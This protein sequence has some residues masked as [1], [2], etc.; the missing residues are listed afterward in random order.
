M[1]QK[2]QAS[3]VG[4]VV[5]LESAPIVK[6]AAGRNHM[7]ALDVKGRVYAWGK[8]EYGQLGLSTMEDGQPIMDEREKPTLVHSLNYI[9][10]IYASE[11][12]SFAVDKMGQTYGWG[13]N[14]LNLL[15]VN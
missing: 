4:E 12:M 1:G 14:K 8:N 7:L 5:F 6:M 3:S 11:N 2:Q 15:M 13:Q 9:V 10:Q